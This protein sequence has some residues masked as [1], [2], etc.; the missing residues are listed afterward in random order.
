MKEFDKHEAIKLWI[1]EHYPK[2]HVRCTESWNDRLGFCVIG[3]DLELLNKLGSIDH[4]QRPLQV[5][6]IDFDTLDLDTG[7]RHDFFF[8]H[9]IENFNSIPKVVANIVEPNYFD[10]LESMLKHAQL[11]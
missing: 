6:E 8:S 2:L 7:K 10:K 11:I 5:V 4:P 3:T 9:Y 1:A